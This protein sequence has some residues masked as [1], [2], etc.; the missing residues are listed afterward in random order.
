MADA[1]P[2][3]Q[4]IKKLGTGGMAAVFLAKDTKTLRQV[5]L[6]VLATKYSK[7][8]NV[9]A[10]FMREANLLVKFNHPNIVKGFKAG[11]YKGLRFVAMEYIDGVSVLELIKKNGNLSEPQAI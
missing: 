3:Y 11:D 10:R 1:I 8:P 4:I 5:A 7:N 9:I 2:G 6:K